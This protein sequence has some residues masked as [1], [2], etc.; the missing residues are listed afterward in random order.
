MLWGWLTHMIEGQKR[1]CCSS[2]MAAEPSA[3]QKKMIVSADLHGCVIGW[4]PVKIEGWMDRKQSRTWMQGA[5][6]AGLVAKAT[7]VEPLCSCSAV[8]VCPNGTFLLNKG[9]ELLQ[10]SASLE[11]EVSKHTPMMQIA[12]YISLWTSY[13]GSPFY[14]LHC[15]YFV[16]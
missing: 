16:R 15:K 13:E 7:V 8:V 1:C 12:L 14:H 3:W 9:K 4:T 11:V 2:V 6:M 5:K 10:T